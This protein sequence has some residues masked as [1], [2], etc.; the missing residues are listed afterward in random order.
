MRKYLSLQLLVGISFFTVCS[1]TF[2]TTYPIP[3]GGDVVG[4]TFTVSLKPGESMDSIAAQ[5]DM[6]IHEILEAN[7]HLASGNLR[8]RQKVTIPARFVL[9]KREYRKNGGIVINVSEL[10][11]YHFSQDGNYVMTYPVA[12]GRRGWR[13]PTT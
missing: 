9:P 1:A 3:K 11:L 13:T 2:S 5:Y 8:V 10:R 12:L 4:Q 7:P 6:S